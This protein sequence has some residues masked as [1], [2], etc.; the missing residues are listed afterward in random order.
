MDCGNRLSQPRPPRVRRRAP[1]L[2]VLLLA[3]ALTGSAA[4]AQDVSELFPFAAG[5][6]GVT[7]VSRSSEV[8]I[9]S[10]ELQD[11]NPGN[12]IDADLGL[13]GTNLGIKLTISD[14]TTATGLA[15]G[16]FTSLRLY[17]SA[18]GSFDPADPLIGTAAPVNVGAPTEID[19]TGAG[20]LRRIPD[21]PASVFFFATAVISPTAAAGHAF[22]VGAAN[23]HI[24]IDETGLGE[25]D[26]EVGSAI[27]AADANHI[28]IAAEQA[29][30]IG[31]DKVTI[32]FG[33]ET[34][35]LVLL[36]LSSLYF[37]RKR[38]GAPSP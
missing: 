35:I 16:D 7:Q 31:G 4:F 28:V 27:I 33:G 2:G 37:I 13:V 17:Q 26:G 36:V 6:T 10:V 1:H 9:Y 21:G 19:A 38:F 11:G 32:P 25:V 5:L 34:W 29:V 18:N 20:V 3:V 23:P 30:T 14:L 12:G 22:R 24:G 15:T 8:L